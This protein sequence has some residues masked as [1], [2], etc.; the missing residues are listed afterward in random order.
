ML[1]L[2]GNI[3]NHSRC[4]THAGT[5]D[6]QGC[7]DLENQPHPS[8][9]SGECL[10][11]TPGPDFSYARARIIIIINKLC[12][13]LCRFSRQCNYLID[14]SLRAFSN[15]SAKQIPTFLRNKTLKTNIFAR[16]LQHFCE[17]R[18]YLAVYLIFVPNYLKKA[19]LC[20][21][22]GVFGPLSYMDVPANSNIFAKTNTLTPTFLRF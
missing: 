11:G 2:Y 21:S 7:H 9:L 19:V 10:R 3:D 6:V 4:R 12:F 20:H 13:I 14:K 17:N 8:L 5:M 22:G 15:I 16:Q 1:D 18:L